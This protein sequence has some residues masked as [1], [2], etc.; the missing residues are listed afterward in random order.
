MD[1]MKNWFNWLYSRERR[2]EPRQA[3][4]RLL[5]YYWDGGTPEPHELRDV[6]S[7]GFYLLT[8]ERWYPGTLVMVS[9]QRIGAAENDSDRSITVQAKVV[10]L[11][12]NGVALELV[13]PMESSLH[14]PYS[15]TVN[16]ANRRTMR[17]FLQRLLGN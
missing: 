10:R 15:G 8:Q 11:G 13:T 12:D 1:A 2:K 14:G 16:G 4:P 17:R 6:S 9:L 7:D 5:A 3:R